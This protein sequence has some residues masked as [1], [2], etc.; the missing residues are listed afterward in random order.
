MITDFTPMT[1]H[2]VAIGYTV[3]I[4]KQKSRIERTNQNSQKRKQKVLTKK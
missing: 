1:I 4:V 2:K 3:K